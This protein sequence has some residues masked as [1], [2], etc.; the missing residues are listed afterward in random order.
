M[1][2]DEM[3]TRE[4]VVETHWRAT[5]MSGDWTCEDENVV[6]GDPTLLATR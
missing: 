6:G 4:T 1:R 3:D 5:G 2:R